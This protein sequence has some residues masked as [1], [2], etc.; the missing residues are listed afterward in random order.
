V[1]SPR[2]AAPVPT[3]AG[4]SHSAMPYTTCVKR[5]IAPPGLGVRHPSAMPYT[6]CVQRAIEWGQG[7]ALGLRN[8]YIIDHQTHEA[9]KHCLTRRGYIEPRLH[10]PHEDWN[11]T[12]LFF[13]LTRT[14]IASV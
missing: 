2:T 6:S 3:V 7:V 14:G 12:K 9:W 10:Q 8:N 11:P 1:V 4:V 13:G 5:D